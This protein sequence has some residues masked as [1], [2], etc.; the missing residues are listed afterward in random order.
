MELFVYKNSKLVTREPR[1]LELLLLFGELLAKSVK[2]V[3]E[4]GDFALLERLSDGV[5]LVA[6]PKNLEVVIELLLIELVGGFHLLQLLLEP[7]HT[8]T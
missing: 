6:L 5:L 3:V 4:F 7:L 1:A 2:D 8:S